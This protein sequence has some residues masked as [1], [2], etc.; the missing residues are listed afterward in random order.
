MM[1]PYILDLQLF[2]D[3]PNANIHVT[4]LVDGH[5]GTE[6]TTELSAEMKTYYEKDLLEAAEPALVYAQFGEK[7]SIPRNGGHTIEWRKM[8]NLP[9]IHDEELL[10]GV[11][12]D[13][14][15]VTVE[16]LTAR[17]HQYGGY[18][19]L[20]DWLDLTAIDPMQRAFAKR[21]GAQAGQTLDSVVRENLLT[22]PMFLYADKVDAEG[23]ATEV[24][25]DSQIDN[26][27]LLTPDVVYRAVS[28][29][30]SNNARPIGDSYVAIVHPSVAVDFMRSEEWI[31]AQK[32][33]NPEKIYRGEIGMFGGVRFVQTTEAKIWGNAGA[34]GGADGNYSVY[35]T[36][37][38]A[39]GAYSVTDIAGG[40]LEYI[41]KGL[42]SAGTED[43]LNQRSTVGWKASL[44]AKV[45]YPEYMLWVKHGS[46]T[47]PTAKS[48]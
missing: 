42:G 33:A 39:D 37:F 44:T 18:L 40:G 16:A 2:A 13:G 8:S 3:N 46:K 4:E 45:L 22:E 24:T 9:K 43:P 30:A 23:N 17:V 27:A 47:M 26:T 19:T 28:I 48:N 1:Y 10:E 32:Y 35:G 31:E 5:S 11:T 21:I 34:A 12:P 6:A 36:L 15:Q 14:Q 38:L 20:S 29:L 41:A 25:A 7:K